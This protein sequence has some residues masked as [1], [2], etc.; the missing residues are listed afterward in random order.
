MSETMK[1]NRDAKR[2][3]ILEMRALLNHSE[4]VFVTQYKGLSVSQMN[5]LRMQLRVSNSSLKV[6]KNR[7]TQLALENTKFSDLAKYF[8]GPT[9][10]AYSS[11]PT[12][13]AKVIV[14]FG[15]SNTNLMLL[16]GKIGQ[17][18]LDQ[19]GIE[20]IASLPSLSELQGK[21]VGILQTPMQR[22]V[23]VCSKPASKIVQIMKARTD[24]M[25]ESQNAR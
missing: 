8:S 13:V 2:K 22:L 20:S 17:L 6:T 25:N 3:F 5:N 9:A 11:D 21:I 7:L 16:A 1:V 12:S 19:G 15:K 18:F 23:I 24:K 14:K 4:C 10:I